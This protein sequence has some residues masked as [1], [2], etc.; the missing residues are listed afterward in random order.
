MFTLYHMKVDELTAAQIEALSVS[1]K[2]KAQ[3]LRFEKDR[4]LCLTAGVLLEEGLLRMGIVNPKIAIGPHGKLYLPDHPSVHFNISHSKEM[5]IV[6]FSD[7]EVGCDVEALRSVDWRVAERWFCP[8]ERSDLLESENPDRDFT[9]LWTCKESF[10]K[11]LGKGL[12]QPMN[13]FRVRLN[14]EKREDKRSE[15]PPLDSCVLEQDVDENPWK[16]T[17]YRWDEY[18]I[19]V[20]EKVPVTEV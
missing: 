3:R 20:C 14:T 13:A 12:Q 8:E 18:Y 6:V 7:R 16:L 5:A 15:K 10:I 4:K 2:K 11:A 19:A 1:R 17:E 9:R